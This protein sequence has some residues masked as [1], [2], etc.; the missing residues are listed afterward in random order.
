MKKQMLFYCLITTIYLQAADLPAIVINKMAIESFG[1]LSETLMIH[2]V[3]IGPDTCIGIDYDATLMARYLML[4]GKKKLY[5]LMNEETRNPDDSAFTEALKVKGLLGL[6]EDEDLAREALIRGGYADF[7]LDSL[8]LY[9]DQLPKNI[10]QD[11]ALNIS[12]QKQAIASY[13]KKYAKEAFIDDIG[14]V[15]SSIRSLQEQGAF[16][17]IASAGGPGE[18][19]CLNSSSAGVKFWVSGATKFQNLHGTAMYNR[20]YNVMMGIDRDTG[21]TPLEVQ[22]QIMGQDR[23]EPIERF[24]KY[25]LIDNSMSSINTFIAAAQKALVEG[26]LVAGTKVIGIHYN[27][28]YNQVTVDKLLKEFH[29]ISGDAPYTGENVPSGRLFGSLFGY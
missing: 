26:K 1:Q 5:H 10:N 27:S 22:Q 25:I 19:R 12:S 17:T 20:V 29:D 18:E 24:K 14:V 7:V 21:Y 3:E 15:K 23:Q 13:I 6:Q 9:D 11:P 2:G 28:E 4:P 8:L 16:V